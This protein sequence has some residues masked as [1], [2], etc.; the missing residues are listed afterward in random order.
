M[1]AAAPV[2][3]NGLYRAEILATVGEISVTL[4]HEIKNRL[5]AIYGA[6]QVV[7]RTLPADHPSRDVFEEVTVEIQRLDETAC[8]LL[9]YARRLSIAMRKVESGRGS[10]S[11]IRLRREVLASPPGA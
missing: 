4:A 11:T 9:V 2:P 5:A 6:V 1:D 8:D 7:A 10:P 3:E